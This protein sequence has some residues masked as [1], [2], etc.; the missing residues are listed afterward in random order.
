FKYQPSGTAQA[1]FGLGLNDLDPR[2][3]AANSAGTMQWVVDTNKNVYLYSP[4]GALLGSWSAG[5]L[6]SSATLTGIATNGSDIWLVD[7]SGGK[8]SKYTGAVSRLSGSQIAAS[9]FNLVSGK[10]GSANP[11]DIVTDGTS[12]WVVD[13]SQKVFKYTLSG[14]L[15]GSWA[16]DPANAHP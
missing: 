6:N 15:L 7:S 14:S 12:F 8:V 11:Q 4:G 16:I 5:G 10:K 2:G 9:S 3:V 1:P 13:G